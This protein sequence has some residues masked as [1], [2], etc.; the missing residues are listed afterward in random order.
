MLAVAIAVA[1]IIIVPRVLHR[2]GDNADRPWEYLDT[3]DGAIAVKKDGTV[4][5]SDKVIYYDYEDQT[6]TTHFDTAGWTNIRSVAIDRVAVGLRYDGTVT[7]AGDVNDGGDRAETVNK[8]QSEVAAWTDIEHIYVWCF[9]VFGIRSDGTVVHTSNYYED[10]SADLSVYQDVV[11]LS[12]ETFWETPYLLLLFEDGTVTLLDGINSLDEEEM[13]EEYVNLFAVH[14]LDPHPSVFYDVSNWKDIVY[15]QATQDLGPLALTKDGQILHTDTY[16]SLISALD[17]Y[18]DTHYTPYFQA[19]YDCIDGWEN[20]K[21]FDISADDGYTFA[22]V[23]EDGSVNYVTAMEAEA[24][25]TASLSGLNDEKHLNT[26]QDALAV[27]VY[28][29]YGFLVLSESGTV[30]T[31]GEPGWIDVTGWNDVKTSEDSVTVDA[32]VTTPQSTPSTTAA[33]TT[34]AAT[35]APTETT[36]AAEKSLG[37]AYSDTVAD[38]ESRYGQYKDTYPFV[39]GV[40]M[41]QLTDLDND[42]TEDLILAYNDNSNDDANYNYDVFTYR[43]GEAVKLASRRLMTGDYDTM[44]TVAFLTDKSTNV[45]YIEEVEDFEYEYVYSHLYTI[46]NGNFTEADTFVEDEGSYYIGDSEYDYMTF[47]DRYWEEYITIGMD[48]TKK[49]LEDAKRLLNNM[50]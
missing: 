6:N 11:Q 45:T 34:T 47:S 32:D 12:C 9:T 26:Y 16:L 17:A 48:T 40:C 43:N 44:K 4:Y 42:G 39:T 24:Y 23:L 35:T 7:V 29:E 3:G 1:A 19:F 37:Q 13:D 10:F 49:D 8:I 5:C 21:Q 28:N 46:K 41:I 18:N 31:V 15:I 36:T 22:A 50:R 33:Q 27:S 20:V 14:N 25:S 38:Y 2:G 30:T